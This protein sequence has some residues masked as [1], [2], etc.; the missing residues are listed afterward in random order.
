[1]AKETHTQLVQA[2]IEVLKDQKRFEAF[3]LYR[4]TIES[5]TDI[6]R[7]DIYAVAVHAFGGPS[8][9][10]WPTASMLEKAKVVELPMEAMLPAPQPKKSIFDESDP[11]HWPVDSA[12]FQRDFLWAYNNAARKNVKK[13]DAPSGGAWLLFEFAMNNPSGF[14]KDLFPKMA[15]AQDEGE[16]ENVEFEKKSIKEIRAMLKEVLDAK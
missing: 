3:T 6:R 10:H 16:A 11:D 15:K 5:D 9:P 4:E 14:V 7:R 8:L 1:M 2:F 12:E 13:G